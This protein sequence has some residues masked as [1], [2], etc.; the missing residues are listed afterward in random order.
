MSL[1]IVA[2]DNEEKVS[3]NANKRMGLPGMYDL[4]LFPGEF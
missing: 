4:S 2:R 1:C 3:V